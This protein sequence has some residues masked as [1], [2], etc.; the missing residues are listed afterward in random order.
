MEIPPSIARPHIPP[1]EYAKYGRYLKSAEW[2][3]LRRL[4]FKRANGICE[5]CH[6][7]EATEAH[8][9]HYLT[10]YREALADLQGVCGDCH[11]FLSEQSDFDP[12][13]RPTWQAS[14]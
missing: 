6:E 9:H 3:T 10:L 8:H 7:G 2:A 12:C 14:E 1:V 4:V 11:D 5:R 13:W